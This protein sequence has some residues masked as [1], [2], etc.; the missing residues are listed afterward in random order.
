MIKIRLFGTTGMLGRYIFNILS[1]N[2]EVICINRIEYDIVNDSWLKLYTILNNHINN[3]NNTN[4][5]KH[6]I[7]NCAGII[8]QKTD[9]LEYNTYIKV[10]TLFPNKLQEFSEKN[11][12]QVIHI[13]TDCV[14]NGNQE[15][16]KNYIEI[17]EHNEKNIYGITKSLGEN[18]DSCI[19]RT[20]IIGEELLNKKSL[21]E[22]VI[23]N[24]NGSINGYTNH[25]WNGITCLTLANI[26]N[27]IIKNNLYWKGI[28]HI[29]SPNYVSKYELCCIINKIYDLNI[30]IIKLSTDN[31]CN[32]TLS[33]IYKNDNINNII[34]SIELQI[35]AQK[36]YKLF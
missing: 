6:I 19:I 15:I 17:S 20:S 16:D 5:M 1:L 29:Y 7:I 9:S 30:N 3:T 25:Y 31:I 12:C 4:N 34:D 36:N 8:P 27:N 18:L 33:S 21:L 10:N 2:Y 26:I 28:R 13:T 23:S 35:L 14:F 11:N 22:W 24:K 32:K